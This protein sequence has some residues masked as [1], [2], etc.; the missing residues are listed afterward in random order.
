M[1]FLSNL[2][3]VQRG[4]IG[5]EMKE[6]AIGSMEYHLVFQ[7][8]VW[9]S[10]GGVWPAQSSEDREVNGSDRIVSENVRMQPSHRSKQRS[11]GR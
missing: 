7:W 5:G 11:R 8:K 2:S 6:E 4:S 9:L 10:E 3:A 1:Q